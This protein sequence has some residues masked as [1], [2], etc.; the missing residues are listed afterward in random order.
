MDCVDVMR[1]NGI[2]PKP[3]PNRQLLLHEGGEVRWDCTRE[4]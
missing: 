2:V 3:D 4:P 1:C